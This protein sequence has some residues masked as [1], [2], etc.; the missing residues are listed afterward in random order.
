MRTKG[1]FCAIV[2]FVLLCSCE[3]TENEKSSNKLVKMVKIE[4]E[5]GSWSVTSEYEYDSEQRIKKVTSI[6]ATDDCSV[7]TFEYLGNVIT[8]NQRTIKHYTSGGADTLEQIRQYYFD[9]NDHVYRI[10]R[11]DDDFSMTDHQSEYS[12]TY[13]GNG[14]L[15]DADGDSLYVKDGN[16]YIVD[17]EYTI[18]YSSYINNGID[19]FW[20]EFGI[21]VPFKEFGLHWFGNN[22]KNLIESVCYL[23]DDYPYCISFEYEFDSDGCPVKIKRSE[24]GD[25]FR[26]WT[27]SYY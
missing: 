24:D 20:S 7:T 15:T 11:E 10:H 21:Y 26:Y 1:W 4:P 17:D 18:T 14:Y 27:I 16:Y 22:N 12:Y 3:K 23:I 6:D 8:E 25:G 13:D 2:V 5:G 9:D 19:L